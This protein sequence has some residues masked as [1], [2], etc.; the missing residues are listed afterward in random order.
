MCK[1]PARLSEYNGE[2]NWQNPYS[3]IWGGMGKKQVHE[4]AN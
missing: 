1:N 3:Y 4:Q 2:Q